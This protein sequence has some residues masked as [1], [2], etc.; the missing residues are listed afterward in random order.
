MFAPV[1]IFAFQRPEH[2]EKLV[3]SLLLNKEASQ[4]DLILFCD[5]KKSE[6]QMV[7]IEKIKDF[8]NRI[9]GFKSVKNVFRPENFG[10]AKNIIS[11]LNEVFS[12]YSSVIVLEED[13]IVTQNFLN[14]MNSALNF[15]KD[16]NVFSVA[17]YTPNVELPEN[18][19]FTTFPILRNCSWGW[20][21]WKDRWQKVDFEV[22]DFKEFIRDKNQR[23]SF[24]ASGSDLTMMLL[25]QQ[26]GIINSWSIRFCYSGFKAGMPT[27][28]PKKSFVINN[29]ADGSGTNVGSTEKYDT[30]IFENVTDFNFSSDLSI[31]EKILH[32][33]KKAYDCSLFRRVIN[34]WKLNRY[35]KSCSLT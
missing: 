20:A 16:K 27:I 15:Y 14:Y 2:L 19:E 8:S 11:G 13:L 30:E 32:S 29:G 33:F 34:Y 7:N 24:N 9:S 10:L 31:N 6:S 17:G 3:K 35:L 4:T 23:E 26:L 25:K 12:E 1:V 5:G 21:T 18:Y 22:S 28:Y